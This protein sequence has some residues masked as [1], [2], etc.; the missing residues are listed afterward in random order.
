MSIAPNIV[1]NKG[2]CVAYAPR[3]QFRCSTTQFLMLK[4]A[5]PSFEREFT[6]GAQI[7]KNLEW[8]EMNWLLKEREGLLD[9]PRSNID[10]NHPHN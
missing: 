10:E 5:L 3:L 9:Q 1:L 8:K 4:D 2:Q 6:Q 7:L